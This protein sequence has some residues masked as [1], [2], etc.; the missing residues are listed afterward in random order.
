MTE[1]EPE[2]K[3]QAVEDD[4]AALI[5]SAPVLRSLLP[6]QD[7]AGLSE[8][9]YCLTIFNA[10]ATRT[11]T[12]FKTLDRAAR[13][14]STVTID[15]PFPRRRFNKMSLADDPRSHMKTI[16]LTNAFLR[17]CHEN[18]HEEDWWLAFLTPSKQAS[19]ATIAEVDAAAARLQARQ[20]N[21]YLYVGNQSSSLLLHLCRTPS[22]RFASPSISLYTHTRL[23]SLTCIFSHLLFFF[24]SLSLSLSFSLVLSLIL[25]LFLFSFPD[26]PII[27][28]KK[29]KRACS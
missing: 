28:R 16:N 23:L 17:C 18:A 29:T 6:H 22:L 19:S 11:A 15:L 25:F 8:T 3:L 21:Q 24:H 4:D 2:R 20:W 7:G 13:R 1:R 14:S 10:A 27:V 26:P 5:I 12:D 9:S